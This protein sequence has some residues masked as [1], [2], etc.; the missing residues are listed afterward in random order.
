MGVWVSA[1][2]SGGHINPAVSIQIFI[3]PQFVKFE[4]SYPGHSGA[5]NLA[6]IP[7]EKSAWWVRQT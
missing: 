4:L 6:W 7:L 5:G 2:I 3:F 1:G